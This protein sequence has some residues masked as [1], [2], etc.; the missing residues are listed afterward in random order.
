M[1]FSISEYTP[2]VSLPNYKQTNYDLRLEMAVLSKKN[3]EYQK[4]LSTIQN[5]Q[6]QSLNVSMLNME[7]K[8]KLDGYNRKINDTL[9]KDLGDLTKIEV[10]NN[11]AGLFQEVAGDTQLIKAS[12][13]SK[14]YQSEYDNVQRLKSSGK[15]DAGYND[16]NEFVWMNWDGG[17]YDFM[18][19]GLGQVTDPN[20]RSEKYTPWRD[21]R[22]PLANMTKLLHEDTVV[23]EQQ[24]VNAKGNPTGY[25]Q[26]VTEAGVAPERVKALYEEQFGTDGISQLQVLSKYEILKARQSGSLEQV[27]NTYQTWSNNEV[28]GQEGLK[29][30]YTQLMDYNIEKAKQKETSAADKLKI[31]EENKQYAQNIA[32]V[33]NN[34][35]AIKGSQKD[36]T[37][38]LSLSNPEILPYI[39]ALQKDQKIKAATNALSWKKDVQELGPDTT[40]LAL[41]KLDAMLAQT[42]IREDGANN[43]MTLKAKLGSDKAVDPVYGSAAD[44]SKNKLDILS[45]YDRLQELQE[46]YTKRSDNIIMAPSFSDDNLKGGNYKNW[47]EKNQDNY[48]AQMWDKFKMSGLAYDAGGNPNKVAFAQWLTD[49]EKNPASQNQGLIQQHKNDEFTGQYLTKKLEEVNGALRSTNQSTQLLLPYARTSNGQAVSQ[50][51]FNS[52]KEIFFNLPTS[53]KSFGETDAQYQA[54]GGTYIKKSLKD[55]LFDLE[56][57]PPKTVSATYISSTGFTSKLPAEAVTYLDNDPGFKQVITQYQTVSKDTTVLGVMESKLPQIAQFG[58]RTT[59]DKDE[60][61]RHTGEITS[62]AKNQSDAFRTLFSADGI[63]TIAIPNGFGNQGIV[64]FTDG[65]AKTLQAAGIQM[66]SGDGTTMEVVTPGRAY[67][68][69]TTPLDPRDELMNQAIREVPYE[70]SYNNHYMKIESDLKG[71]K[72]LTIWYP[73]GSKIQRLAGTAQTDINKVIQATKQ[74]IDSSNQIKK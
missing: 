64:K 27:Y 23:R 30:Q 51:D 42:K 13:L 14:E 2:D 43:R 57:T 12:R 40:Y 20:Y 25:L 15:K 35:S 11:I 9:S 45:S 39:Y 71:D 5:L 19:K 60:I 1:N 29:K 62:A 58:H 52:G 65:Y 68:F 61:Q 74:A 46:G 36:K 66:P 67:L 32:I 16:I 34:I 72:Y 8:Q 47:Y 44:I 70:T 54:R 37:E 7:G 28:L 17:Y 3:Q 49:E 26:K 38:F 48:F 4:V 33:E 59:A 18:Q 53:L 21:L 31:T 22:T 50:Q 55:V 41:K 73:D 24:S 6:N 56:N 10:Q 63:E 69:D